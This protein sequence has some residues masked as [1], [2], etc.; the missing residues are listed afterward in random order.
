[1]TYPEPERHINMI[2]GGLDKERDQCEAQTNADVKDFFYISS[3]EDWRFLEIPNAM[4]QAFYTEFDASK[5]HGYI[6]ICMSKCK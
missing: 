1:M 2:L 6:F 5:S 4:E 3:I